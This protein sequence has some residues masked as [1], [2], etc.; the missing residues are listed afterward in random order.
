MPVK[1]KAVKDGRKI[2]KTGTSKA[3]SKQ[4]SFSES[5]S[6]SDNDGVDEE[7]MERLMKAL[8]DD[9]LDDFDQTQLELA[10]GDEDNWATEDEGDGDDEA[11]DSEEGGSNV[12]GK[13]Y[14]DEEMDDSQEEDEDEEG[15]GEGEGLDENVEQG[16]EQDQIALDDVESVDEDAVPRQKIEIDNEVRVSPFAKCAYMF[17]LKGQVA[18]ERIRETIQLDPSLPWTETLVLSYPQTIDVDVNDDLNREL[19]LY[20]TNLSTTC[21]F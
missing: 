9:G 15:E 3:P 5:D 7:G 11:S 14:L 21:P 6:D 1:L 10:L 2:K 8:G 20:A 4:P 18:L 17:K 19:S 12:A 13:V 16:D